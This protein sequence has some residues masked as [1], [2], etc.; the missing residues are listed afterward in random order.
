MKKITRYCKHD[1]TFGN[2]AKNNNVLKT[3]A[4]GYVW[5]PNS[6]LILNVNDAFGLRFTSLVCLKK[7]RF[8]SLL[9]N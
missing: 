1:I 2:G 9:N 5:L 7:I 4:V 3:S 8:F 6:T